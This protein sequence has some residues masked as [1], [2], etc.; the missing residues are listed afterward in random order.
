MRNAA[1]FE[2]LLQLVSSTLYTSIL[3]TGSLEIIL[4]SLLLQGL[5]SFYQAY[6]EWQEGRWPEFAAKL[7]MGV[8]RFHEAHAQ[9][10]LIQRRNLF[11]S[12][13]KFGRLTQQIEKGRAAGHLIS[14]P[15]HNIDGEVILLDAEGKPFNFG[16]HFHAY[17]KGSVKGMN[18]EFRTQLID[19]KKMT[20]LDFKVNHVFREHLQSI[21]S[22]MQEFSSPELREF[23]AL[24]NSHAKDIRIENVPLKLSPQIEIGRAWKISFDGLGSVHIG[25]SIEHPNLYDRVKVIIEEEK[26]LY[27]LH[28]LLSFFN[29]GDA[30]RISSPEDIERLKVGQ[31]FRIFYPTEATLLERNQA[32]FTLPV[33]QLKAEILQKIPDMREKFDAYLEKMQ[34]RE[35]LPGRIRYSVPGLGE[36]VHKLGGRALITT[37]TGAS[38]D[39]SLDRVVSILKMGMLASEMRYSHDMRVS[40]LSPSLD[41][42][43]GGADSVFT[44][45]LT[46]KNFREAMDL[47]DLYW[48]DV[49]LLFSLDV[50]EAG[51]YQYHYDAFGSRQIDWMW[52]GYLGRP[53]ILAFTEVEQ[54]YGFN[55]GNEV[56]IKERISPEMIK[57]LIVPTT[58]MRDDLIVRLKLRNA[59]ILDKAGCESIFNIPLERFV[60]VGTHLSEGMLS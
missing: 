37:L 2:Q 34:A 30:L 28:E 48:G 22:E 12:V 59:V 27:E 13:E 43:T 38:G 49:R 41:F 11:L 4:A 33:D 45:F 60:H 25:A 24:S 18:L 5:I 16:A 51:T 44:Q 17:G 58:Q 15:L 42:Y 6:G 7:A 8:I 31:L 9:L 55:F 3:F 39:E 20:E 50:L 57:G 47:N 56:M 23:L 10:Q 19:G 21:I 14:S 40:G 32:F 29:L 52:G 53:D 46:E 36:E 54:A 1:L 26:S 35:I